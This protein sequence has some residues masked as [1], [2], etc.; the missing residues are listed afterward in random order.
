MTGAISAQGKMAGGC[1]R[2]NVGGNRAH[3]HKQMGGMGDAE[4][5]AG[6]AVSQ[7]GPEKLGRVACPLQNWGWSQKGR[8]KEMSLKRCL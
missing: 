3:T 2:G 6:L 8:C 1:S 4:N 5:P 7:S